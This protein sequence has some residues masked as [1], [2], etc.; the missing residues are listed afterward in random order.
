M[1]S[2]DPILFKRDEIRIELF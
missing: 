2:Q 1:R